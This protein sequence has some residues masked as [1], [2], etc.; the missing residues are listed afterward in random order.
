MIF[1]GGLAL[2]YYE[3]GQLIQDDRMPFYI[4]AAAI[5]YRLR[6]LVTQEQGTYFRYLPSQP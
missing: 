5:T 4:P 1:L 3:D 6:W 2:F